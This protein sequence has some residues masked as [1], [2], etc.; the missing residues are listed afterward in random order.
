MISTFDNF[1]DTIGIIRE[2]RK[3]KKNTQHRDQKKKDN[4][5]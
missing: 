4:T 5:R 2:S 3:Q 1:E